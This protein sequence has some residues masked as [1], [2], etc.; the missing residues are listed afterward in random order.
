MLRRPDLAGRPRALAFAAWGV[1]AAAVLALASGL[2]PGA[3]VAGDPGV[4]LIASRNA[5]ARPAQPLEI[6]LPSI[7]GERVP[8]IGP[9]FSLHGDHAHAVSSELFPLVSAPL[10]AV[11]GVRGVYILPA[12]GFLLALAACAALAV[13][14]DK[15]RGRAVPIAVCALATPL[16][17]YGLEF[18]EHAPAAGLVALATVLL[19]KSATTETR[20][21]TWVTDPRGRA[22]SAGLLLGLAVLLR[23]EALWYAVALL[24]ASCLLSARPGGRLLALAAAA[25]LLALLPSVLYSLAH[26]SSLLPAHVLTNAGALAGG[27]LAGRIAILSAW[28]GPSSVGALAVAPVV[29]LALVPA[30]RAGRRFLAVVSLA[31]AA[32]VVLT[33]PNDGGAQWTPRYLLLA[34]VPVAILAADGVDRLWRAGPA[35]MVIVTLLFASSAWLQR[36]AYRHLRGSKQTHARI[37]DFFQRAV[38]PGERAVTDLW[39]LDQL[40]AAAEP[41][42]RLLYADT[43]EY[44]REILE[45][46]DRAG[47]AAVTL[48]QSRDESP[49]GLAWTSTCYVEVARDEIPERTL[50]A[51]RLERRCDQK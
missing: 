21:S 23:P 8:F 49:Q 13:S 19:V 45:R 50:T 28:L 3:F 14:L 11:F 30:R 6:P 2:P 22:L 36:A 44:A 47:A 26:F 41:E 10:L 5:L 27:W 51:T 46:L 37:V 16:V 24:S 12:A 4:K 17:F 25:L 20:D 31:Y 38:A 29:L 9:F 18:W 33:A 48:L 7:G 40:V 32:L 1:L 42:G 35:G 39:W 43:P 34:A 15:R